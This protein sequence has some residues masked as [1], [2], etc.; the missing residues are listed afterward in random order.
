MDQFAVYRFNFFMLEPVSGML[1]ENQFS[2][3]A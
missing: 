1:I 3:V 2:M